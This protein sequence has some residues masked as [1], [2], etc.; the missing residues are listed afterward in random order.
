MFATIHTA[1]GLLIASKI[2]DPWGI[3]FIGIIFH[4]ILDL[5]PHGDR[6]LE[7]GMYDTGE[8]KK[9]AIVRVIIVTLV[10]LSISASLFIIFLWMNNFVN[11]QYY[12]LA[13]AAVLLPDILMGFGKLTY[14]FNFQGSKNFLIKLNLKIYHFHVRVHNFFPSKMPLWQGL[15]L[16]LSITV[17]FIF[18]I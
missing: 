6:Y 18:L 5:I 17:F 14:L 3:F 2:S 12:L 11:W 10:D 15:L 8:V 1:S 13:L 9:K 7:T 16:Q 4:Y